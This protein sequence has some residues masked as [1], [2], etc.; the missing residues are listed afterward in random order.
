VIEDSNDIARLQDTKYKAKVRSNNPRVHSWI[1]TRN[2]EAFARGIV[3]YFDP[4]ELK[5]FYTFL[6]CASSSLPV[7]PRD[8]KVK[9]FS[10]IVPSRAALMAMVKPLANPHALALRL[11][12]GMVKIHVAAGTL[13]VEKIWM[14]VSISSK[15]ATFTLHCTFL[16]SDFRLARCL[17]DVECL[18]LRNCREGVKLPLFPTAQE[19]KVHMF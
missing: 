9:L 19:N 5:N 2:T 15:H 14:H 6:L 7:L 16:F 11:P 13:V 1:R 17:G 8:L 4:L 3:G 18:L 12:R 10:L